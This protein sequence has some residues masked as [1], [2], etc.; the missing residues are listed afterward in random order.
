MERS[1]AHKTLSQE[2]GGLTYRALQKSS[3]GLSAGLHRMA[4]KLEQQGDIITPLKRKLL[5]CGALSCIARY[6]C[7]VFKGDM[8]NTFCSAMKQRHVLAIM[9]EMDLW[10]RSIPDNVLDSWSHMFRSSMT[11]TMLKER[12]A[13]YQVVDSI[14]PFMFTEEEIDQYYSQHTA[15][16]DAEMKAQILH[17]ISNYYSPN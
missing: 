17:I 16:I 3:K 15:Q 9:R 8:D 11:K 10:H 12:A 4:Q 7:L 2:V 5:V 1:E 14:V 6:A 13:I